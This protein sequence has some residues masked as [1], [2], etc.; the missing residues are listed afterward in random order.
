M[1]DYKK[2]LSNH[3]MARRLC[4]ATHAVYMAQVDIFLSW[5]AS[6]GVFPE[7]VESAGLVQYL[8]LEGS[9]SACGQRRAM[10]VN[11]YEFVLGQGYKLQGLPYAK[12]RVK[13]PESLSPEQIQA[14]FNA[15][16]NHKQRL[17]LKITYACGLRVSETTHIRLADFRLKKNILTGNNYYELKVTGKG[18]K[19][20]LVPVPAE[21]MNE[22]AAYI[23]AAQIK[24]YLFPGQFKAAYSTKSLELVFMRAKTACGITVPGNIHLLR[25]SRA[26]HLINGNMNDRNVMLMMGW[27]NQKTINHYHR[28]N[29]AAIKDCVDQIDKTIQTSINKNLQ[30]A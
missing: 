29:T 28:A 12:K 14:I 6:N 15:T 1:R 22:V 10:L 11:L 9:I 24:D 23:K 18:I 21:T 25:K 19:Q 26:T 2:E 13:V 16:P 7:D 17:A 27:Q 8:A 30:L 4:T 20:R 3:I 5:C